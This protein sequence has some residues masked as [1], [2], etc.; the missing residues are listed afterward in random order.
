LALAKTSHFR[1]FGG[2]LLEASI[3]SISDIAA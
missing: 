3:G 1:G 2:Y